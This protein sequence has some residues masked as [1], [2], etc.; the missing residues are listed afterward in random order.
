[1]A[2]PFALKA[3]VAETTFKSTSAFPTTYQLPTGSYQ[4]SI[5]FANG[6]IQT[7]AAKLN[8]TTLSDDSGYVPTG[9][10]RAPGSGGTGVPDTDD[11]NSSPLDFGWDVILLM[12]LL[13]F[14]Y[15]YKIHRK[16]T[17]VN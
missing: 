17:T 9:P 2:I 10:Q 12:L 8:G 15:A 3:Q 13:A 4:P 14:L 11:T 5:Q 7:A 16:T 1:M 6:N